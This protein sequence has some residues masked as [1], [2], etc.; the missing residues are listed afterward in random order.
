MH[1]EKSSV[2]YQSFGLAS[3]Q[4]CALAF[5]MPKST[6]GPP[7]TSQGFTDWLSTSAVL[8][9]LLGIS[10]A[11]VSLMFWVFFYFTVLPNVL[12]SVSI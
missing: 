9:E 7:A 12:Q 2:I 4:G 6:H 1:L 10:E 8:G 5:N 11:K 3:A